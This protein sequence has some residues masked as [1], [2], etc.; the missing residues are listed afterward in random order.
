M[1]CLPALFGFGF[2]YPLSRAAWQFGLMLVTES[3]S[4]LQNT[5]QRSDGGRNGS[6]WIFFAWPGVGAKDPAQP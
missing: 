5:M 4:L 6:L 1:R 2:G 3:L